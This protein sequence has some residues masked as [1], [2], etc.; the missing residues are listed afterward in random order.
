M[1]VFQEESLMK[2]R[3]W[4]E[5]RLGAIYRRPTLREICRDELS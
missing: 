3:S 1:V 2:K 4:M 5:K